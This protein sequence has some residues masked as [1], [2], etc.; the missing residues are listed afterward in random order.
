MPV[1][2]LAAESALG[3]DDPAEDAPLGD[4]AEDAAGGLDV[5]EAGGV[6]GAVRTSDDDDC[7][8]TPETPSASASADSAGS[9]EN[10]FT[11]GSC[12]GRCAWLARPPALLAR[13]ACAAGSAAASYPRSLH[14]RT[15]AG[16]PCSPTPH[17]YS[18][19]VVVSSSR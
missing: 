18:I 9:E 13:E 19:A 10:A 7:A 4:A 5:D 14:R 15:P 16:S 2:S 3:D 1:R 17:D 12:A 6:T 8:Q 11:D